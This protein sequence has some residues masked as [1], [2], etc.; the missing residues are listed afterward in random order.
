MAAGKKRS[1]RIFIIIILI[2]AV[3]A[4]LTYLLLT[5]SAGL[6]GISPANNQSVAT[7]P[8]ATEM[9]DIVIASQ[10][11]T[12]GAVI[13][14]DYLTTIQYPKTQIPEGTFFTSIEDAVGTKAKYDIDP[15]V[16]LT[17]NMVIHEDE[18]SLASFDIP[19]GMTAFSIPI[20]PETGVAFAPQKG[21]HVM[22]VGCMLLSELDTDYQTRLP[23]VVDTT[24]TAGATADSAISNS[25]SVAAGDGQLAYY[26]RYEVDPSTNQLIYLVPSETQRPQLVCQ[27]IIQDASILQVG[28]FSNSQ[29]GTAVETPAAESPASTTSST[30]SGSVTLIVSPQ[31]TLILN[32][33]LLS[34]SKLSLALRSAG[35]S[36]T[37]STDPVTLQYVMQQKNIPEPTKLPYGVEP[38]VDSLAYPGFNDYILVQP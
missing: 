35:D 18:G 16:P 37:V 19:D 24:T 30:Y 12:R 20:S 6:N 15:A 3:G 5:G 14:S 28:M 4:V 9:V 7:E 31:D 26:G 27:T 17:T 34:G 33:L 32:Y 29:T 13:T 8:P 25:I 21:D 22:V 38:R 2:I 1:S 10:S 11:I 36:T 23:N